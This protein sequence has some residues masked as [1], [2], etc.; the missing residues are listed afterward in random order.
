KV[1]QSSLWNL[2]A[3]LTPFQ[4]RRVRATL[5]V[6][7]LRVSWDKVNTPYL[8]ALSSILHPRPNRFGPRQLRIPRPKESVYQVPIDV[9]VYFEGTREQLTNC[10]KVILD[11]PGGGFVAMNPRTHDDRL[12]SWAHLCPG[13]PIISVDYRKAPEFPYPAGLND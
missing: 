9:W 6:D 3:Q 1:N 12:L 13:V 10:H 4:V 11:F 8:K 7:H 2:A 5:T